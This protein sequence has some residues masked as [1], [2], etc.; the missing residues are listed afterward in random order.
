MKKV[1]IALLASFAISIPLAVCSFK[2]VSTVHTNHEAILYVQ[3]QG[4]VQGY[5][6]GTFKPDAKINRAEFTKIIMESVYP[7]EA[8]VENCFSDVQ[9]NDWFADYVCNAKEKGVVGGYNDGTF[10]PA[11]NI[12]FAEAAKII[13]I[14][15]NFQTTET[16]IWFET[17]VRNLSSIKAI[18]TTIKTFNGEITRGEMAEMIFRIRTSNT[19]KASATYEQIQ[20]G[21]VQA[22]SDV[23]ASVP[24]DQIVSGGPPKDGIPPID[25]PVFVSASQASEFLRNDTL[26]VLV[27]NQGETKY[28]P[29]NILTWH[30]IV[31]DT[32]G[33]KPLTITFCPLCA[34]AFVFER[35]I[36]GVTYDFGT[37]GKLYESNLVM[38]D[39]QTDSYWSQILAQAIAGELTGTKL[40]IFPSSVIEFSKVRQ[41]PGLQVLSTDT[42][43]ERDYQNNPY[44]EY[45]SED[46]T[47]FPITN[48]DNRLP[49]K[50]LM[51]A[52]EINGKQKA[53]VYKDLLEVRTL[54]DTFNNAIL[55]IS[56]DPETNQ[57]TVLDQFKNS[58]IGY[59]TFWFSWSTHHEGGSF[60][61]K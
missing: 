40:K 43:H 54:Q 52:V 8:V 42:G 26:G 39:R 2:D 6:D 11:E 21:T 14:A 51:F 35:D 12:N 55:T 60:W 49:D 23:L 34:S 20:D 44:Q 58:Y 57:I 61:Q 10:K 56:V 36:S 30:E 3:D 22:T 18:P 41:I 13:N 37:S 47:L 17:Y 9:S 16:D 29:Y 15:F 5:E 45:Q 19:S 31:N 46:G 33:K 4:I 38:Y 28:Y 25:E 32:V 24:L 27:Q 59:N 48:V 1:F 7:G 50:T 53:Y